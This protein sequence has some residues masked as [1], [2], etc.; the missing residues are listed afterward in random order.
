MSIQSDHLDTVVPC[1]SFADPLVVYLQ[2]SRLYFY[3]ALAD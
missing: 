3:L 2:T 1:S